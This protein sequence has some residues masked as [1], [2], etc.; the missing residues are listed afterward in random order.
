MVSGLGWSHPS[1]G[2]ENT[3]QDQVASST[4]YYAADVKIRLHGC[5]NTL[6]D[7]CRIDCAK[8]RVRQTNGC[9]RSSPRFVLNRAGSNRAGSNRA[10]SNRARSNRA[11]SNRAGS[12][13]A[14]ARVVGFECGRNP[15]MH[16]G[17]P[18]PRLRFVSDAQRPPA[19]PRLLMH[20]S[21]PDV[22]C[23]SSG[24][25]AMPC[26]TGHAT[27]AIPRPTPRIV[28]LTRLYYSAHFTHPTPNCDA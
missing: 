24:M 25:R 19:G 20:T 3:L 21:I 8:S 12:S 17:R 22:S 7:D 5:F 2:R 26:H 1:S 4:L 10:G 23:T 28:A 6:R 13:R 16:S 11:G 15:R 27:P 9:V 18:E 14:V